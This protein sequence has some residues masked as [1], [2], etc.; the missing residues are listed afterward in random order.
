MSFGG[1]C[2]HPP[3]VG[4]MNFDG[5]FSTA[6]SGDTSCLWSDFY[7]APENVTR[8]VTLSAFVEAPCPGRWDETLGAHQFGTNGKMDDISVA[9]K[10]S[11][12]LCPRATRFQDGDAP[13]V[14]ADPFFQVE[15]T[16]V[17]IQDASPVEAAN[18]LLDFLEEGGEVGA[19]I[20][21]VNLVK[22]TIKAEVFIEGWSCTVKAR[23]YAKSDG[24]TVELQKRRGSAI[25]FNAL[26]RQ[27]SQAL[28]SSTSSCLRKQLEGPAGMCEAHAVLPLGMECNDDRDVTS[29]SPRMCE[30]FVS[31]HFQAEASGSFASMAQH[32]QTASQLCTTH[33]FSFLRKLLQVDSFAIAYP[34]SC[35][36]SALAQLPEAQP[37]F[38]EQELLT[39]MLQAIQ[40][41]SAGGL[42]R[43]EL[44]HA[45]SHVVRKS[46]HDFTADTAKE[47]VSL[48]IVAQKQ[49]DLWNA[50][51]AVIN[52]E[53]NQVLRTLSPFYGSCLHQLHG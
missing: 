6:F 28:S 11:G 9:W 23:L 4:T 35:A 37:L 7:G 31:E 12:Q 20:E 32:A 40:T 1:L 18:C 49:L 16:S 44:A 29:P 45:A 53:L 33:A 22:F 41:S 51:D 2:L 47:L 25:A 3:L 8:G 17:T 50:S 14:P 10:P 27:V 5:A 48:V 36:L 43:L 42:A 24:C 26:F 30:C 15:A 39:S 13:P 19:S 38:L 21:K 46:G 34:L 52:N